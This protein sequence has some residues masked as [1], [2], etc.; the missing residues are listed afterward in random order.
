MAMGR[1]EGCV[2]YGFHNPAKG[3][4]I[5]DKVSSGVKVNRNIW[6]GSGT[7]AVR[8]KLLRAFWRAVIALDF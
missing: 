7:Y 3:A 8:S 5:E 2:Q 4:Q 1:S 6:A